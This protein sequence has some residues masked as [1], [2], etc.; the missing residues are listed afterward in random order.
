MELENKGVKGSR[1]KNMIIKTLYFNKAMSCAG[2]SELFDKSIPSIAK[3][4][5]ELMDE[6]F[7]VEDGYAP[8]SGGR[9]PLMY[10]VK[11]NTMYILA[12][13]L[14]QLTARI[15][16]FDL[17]N[18][19]VADMV[20]FELKLLNNPD[21]LAKLTTEINSY[22]KGSGVAKEKIAGI[23]IGMPGFINVTEGIN[24]TYLDAGGESLTAYR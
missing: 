22:I 8:S 6:G 2:L 15:Q 19:A 13:A 23:G 24:Y 11:A 3:A 14:D 5:N 18:N 12:I 4:V 10:S 17:L 9:R 7:V 21:A 16:L 20:T 1:L